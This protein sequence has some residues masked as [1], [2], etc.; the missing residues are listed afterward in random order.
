MRKHSRSPLRI[1]VRITAFLFV[2][3]LAFVFY[4]VTF[5]F[6]ESLVTEIERRIS[7]GNLA[8]ETDAVK[9]DPLRG[10]V[11]DNVR[12]YRK[13][14]IGP[15]AAD[16]GQVVVT[17]DPFALLR[18]RSCLKK[19]KISDALFRPDM[20]RGPKSAPRPEFRETRF[21]VV[22]DRCRVYGV[23]I[24]SLSGE[25]HAQGS[26][27]QF[28]DVEGTVGNSDLRG[29]LKGHG[30]Y[31]TGT[32]V[33]EGH[34]EALLDPNL[35][36][37]VLEARKMPFT[38]KLVKRFEFRGEAP[39]CK[40]SFRKVCVDEGPF[41]IESDFRLKDCRYRGVDILRADGSV[42]FDSSGTNLT[43]RV[44]PFIV[45]RTE[46]NMN[47][48]FTVSTAEKLV[49]FD[50]LSAINPKALV[51]MIGVLTNDFQRICRFEG[52]VKIAA[53]GT[54]HYGDKTQ[55][56]FQATVTGSGMYVHKF[57]VEE[58]AFTMRM[59]GTTNT[60]S[61]IR[62]RI[63][64]G[65]FTG[66]AKFVM[67]S[68]SSTNIGYTIEGT[69]EDADFKKLVKAVMKD[70]EKDY[71][72]RLSGHIIVT[73]RTGK[74]NAS[75]A[76]GKGSVKIKDGRVFL[77]PVFGGLSVHVARIIP[78]LDFVL[79]QSDAKADFTIADGKI[80]S[81]KVLIQGDVL[82]LSG[83]GDF[84]LDKQLDF[85]VQLKLMKEHTLVAKLLR[86]ITYPIS[87]LFEFRLRGS[88][89]DPDWYPVNFSGDLLE[90]LGLKSSRKKE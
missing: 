83:Y 10:L 65:K 58:C 43:V 48:S 56:D 55:A 67:P 40:A 38:A 86:A 5:G 22:L 12:L 31:N 4:L 3:V 1:L 57:T 90:K 81:D 26:S 20:A 33:L 73:G 82:S 80:H 66:T 30:K 36:L 71:R 47:G 25:V 61:G 62:G 14:I 24:E 34:V 21:S 52:P 19:I 53:Q 70:T 69:V 44:N 46:G 45:M 63:Y 76:R 49:E 32:R 84:Y 16:A 64:G 54:A 79:R 35:L 23:D 2:M 77:M 42:S 15:A 39:E 13:G 59:L 11:M 28:R 68:G 85:H 17:I 50:V 8:I 6:P 88:C 72:G 9:L 37:P 18:K 27:I 74:G 60:L 51:R 87:K 29:D 75:T 41:T 89:E 7:T 78:G